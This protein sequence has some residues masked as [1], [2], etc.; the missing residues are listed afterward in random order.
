LVPYLELADGRTIV[1]TDGA[2]DIR[3]A[4]DGK[5]LQVT[6]KR[7]AVLRQKPAQFVDPGLT[8]TVNWTIQGSTLIRT[9]SI[10]SSKPLTIRRFYVDFPATAGTVKTSFESGHRSDRFDSPDGGVAVSITR[11]SFPLT[12]QLTATGDS[13]L[14]KGSRGPIPLIVRFEGKDIAMQPGSPLNWTISLTR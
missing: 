9:E 8:T 13:A 10:L 3:P 6:W 12:S 7:W 2:D 4:E 14:G 11:S 1:A 5:S